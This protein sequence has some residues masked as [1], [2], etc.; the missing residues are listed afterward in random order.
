MPSEE[1]H[2]DIVRAILE[3]LRPKHGEIRLLSRVRDPGLNNPSSEDVFFFVPDLHLISP[4][5]QSDFGTWG[6][7]HAKSGCLLAEILEK[8]LVL[9]QRWDATGEAKLRTFQIGDLFDIWREFPGRIDPGK[10]ADD[11]YG[12]LRDVLYRRLF[13][14]L[15]CLKSVVLIGNHDTKNGTPLQEI[16]FRLR[17]F[18][19]TASDQAKPFLMMLHGDVFAFVEKFPA[20]IKAFFV[21]LA[22]TA[23]PVNTYWVA[24]WGKYMCQINKPVD[25]LQ[26]AITKPVHKLASS[27]GAL[28]VEPDTVLPDRLC[29]ETSSVVSPMHPFLGSIH[30][31]IA[32]SRQDDLWASQVRVVALGHTHQ[33]NMVFS[34]P[35]GEAPLLVM[36]VGAWIEKCRYPLDPGGEVVAEPSA[37]LGVIS[38]NDARIYQVRLP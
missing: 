31:M 1:R 38:G 32:L 18:S 5:R 35:P 30:E 7:N 10:I 6:F 20:F 24:K 21:N 36:D 23:T 33:A 17:A 2:A 16:D 34:Q 12:D 4:A 13:T 14:G 25:E 15:S 19:R 26:K 22:G 37:Q 9:K 28:R 27:A 8:I 3:V 11:T 29:Q